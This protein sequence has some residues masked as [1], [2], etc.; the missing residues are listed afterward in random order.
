M[1]T[2]VPCDDLD[3]V[4]IIVVEPPGPSI[5]YGIAHELNEQ[6]MWLII[7]SDSWTC[8]YS[9]DREMH[10]LRTLRDGDTVLL[11][12]EYPNESLRWSGHP[13]MSDAHY[14][15]SHLCTAQRI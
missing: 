8:G 9:C 5:D 10:P 7:K 15:A 13:Y 14:I 4:N 12:E 3:F 11:A 2:G 6:N 1:L